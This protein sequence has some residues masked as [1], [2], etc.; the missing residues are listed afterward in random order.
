LYKIIDS[1]TEVLSDT[2]FAVSYF[3]AANIF[4]F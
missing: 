3:Y 4:C 2:P 1:I